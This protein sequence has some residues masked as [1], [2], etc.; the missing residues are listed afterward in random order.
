MLLL[1]RADTRRIAWMS[2]DCLSS[3]W[4]TS[5]PTGQIEFSVLEMPEIITQ[6]A[7]GATARSAAHWQ[8]APSPVVGRRAAAAAL[9]LALAIQRASS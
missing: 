8:G 1:P 4:V 5:H 3:Q 2:A 6:Y 7:S 9:D